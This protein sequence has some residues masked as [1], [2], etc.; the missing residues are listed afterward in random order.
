MDRKVFIT[1]DGD[2]RIYELRS[3]VG[4]YSIEANESE[5]VVL[6]FVAIH[7]GIS[8]SEVSKV[9]LKSRNMEHWARIFEDAKRSG[10][11]TF[12]DLDRDTFLV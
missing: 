7:D 5:Y 1:E 8:M 9:F 6:D 4:P 11:I 12:Q 3:G 10:Y 2:Q